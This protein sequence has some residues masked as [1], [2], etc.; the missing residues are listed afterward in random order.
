MPEYKCRISSI[1]KKIKDFI[2]KMRGKSDKKTKIS[3][4]RNRRKDK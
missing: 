3:S 4:R 2:V 1:I